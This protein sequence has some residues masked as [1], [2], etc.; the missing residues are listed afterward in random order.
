VAVTS[1][2]GTSD[3]GADAGSSDAAADT[4]TTSDAGPAPIGIVQSYSGATWTANTLATGVQP[5]VVIAPTGATVLVNSPAGLI[6]YP[7]AGG[8]PTT[9]DPDGGVGMFTSDGLSVIY[10]T[11]A[12]ALKR[13]TIATPTPTTLAPT[14]FAG[15]RAKSPDDKWVLGYSMLASG[16]LSDLFLTSASAP[17]TPTTLSPGVT[18]GLFQSDGF[19][20]DSSRAIYYTDIA[21]GVGNFFSVPSAGGT[22][23]AVATNVWLHYAA[24]AAKVV[25]NDN[26]DESTSTGDIRVVDTSQSSAPT[27]LVSLADDTFYIAGSKDKVVY[28]WSY[29][30]GTMAGLWVTPI[31]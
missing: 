13:S 3:G 11:P 4:G 27:L 14:G 9:I 18:A 7:V 19:T 16:D 20:A 25:F 21:N 31:P 1:D 12:N 6:A 26:Y 2:G 15:I 28:T 22:P 17:G 23:T 30:P 5:R 24:L 10:T 29:I 8:A